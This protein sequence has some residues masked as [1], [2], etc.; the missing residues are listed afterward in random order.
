MGKLEPEVVLELIAHRIRGFSEGLG[1]RQGSGGGSSSAP[2]RTIA[3]VWRHFRLSHLGG[4]RSVA[5]IQWGK[6][7]EDARHP[8]VHKTDGPSQ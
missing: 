4:G 5:C 3:H 8:T 6:A 1:C 2:Q 7:R